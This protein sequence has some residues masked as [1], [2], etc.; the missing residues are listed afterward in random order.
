MVPQLPNNRK[1]ASQQVSQQ[2]N[3]PPNKWGATVTPGSALNETPSNFES[4]RPRQS[5][6]PDRF[7]VRADESE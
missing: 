2:R 5:D 1:P 4:I 3:P 7:D 6:T